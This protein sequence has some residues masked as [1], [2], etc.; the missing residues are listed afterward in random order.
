MRKV[1]AAVDARSRRSG[2]S[3]D[4][5]ACAANDDGARGRAAE[6]VSPRCLLAKVDMRHATVDRGPWLSVIL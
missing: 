4:S 3:G 1:R 5:N 2:P 6:A